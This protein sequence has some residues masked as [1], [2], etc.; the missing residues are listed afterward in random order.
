MG[1]DIEKQLN[2][3][4]RLFKAMQYKRA[5]KVYSS[6]GNDLMKIGNFTHAK[7]SY[8][9]A[10][11]SALEDNKYLNGIEFLRS[12]ANAS[13]SNNNFLE[14]YQFFK[15]ALNYIPSLRNSSDRNYHFINFATLS[16][17]CLFIN[18]KQEEGLNLVKKIKN[19]VDND[20]FKENALIKLIKNFTVATKDKNDDYVKLIIKD[21]ENYK[22]QGGEINLVKQAIVIAKTITTL[23]LKS[24]LDKKIY[25]TKDTL[26][27]TID[28]DTNSLLN[29][30][31]ASFYNYK[32]KDLTILKIGL[33]ASDNLTVNSKPDLPIKITPGQIQK[34]E[35][36]IKPHFQMDKPFIGPFLFTSELD[37]SLKFFYEFPEIL[38]PK[39]I[40]PP[41]T[42]DVS[43]KNLKTPLIGQSFPYE[44]LIE[45][46]SEGDALDLNIE[47]EFPENLKVMRGTLK[48]QIY[49]LSINE[50]IKWEINVKPLEAGDYSIKVKL[51]FKDPDQNQIGEIKE[52]P[53]SIKL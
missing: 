14:A 40:S 36:L 22:F 12:A 53:L 5:A 41:P 7:E 3:A 20:Y 9:N 35:F 50:N 25:T 8:F 1:K 28:F 19:Y 37:G 49:S 26:K 27:L 2:K 51:S 38:Y 31:N 32:I 34:L 45:N 21:F 13:L 52:F 18:G 42:L 30:S 47:I 44:I 33:N 24:N 23:K 11:K 10:A 4:D 46:K 48:K 29:I 6:A 16:Y 17:L 15:E 39:L 43:T